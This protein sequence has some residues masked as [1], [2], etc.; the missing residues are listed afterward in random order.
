MF[1]SYNKW[2]DVKQR[3]HR[4]G[5]THG[6]SGDHVEDGL[7]KGGQYHWVGVIDAEQHGGRGPRRLLVH[8][9]R[10][11][12]TQSGHHLGQRP[13]DLQRHGAI[14]SCIIGPRK[15]S[16]YECYVQIKLHSG[17]VCDDQ[18]PRAQ[19]ASLKDELDMFFIKSDSLVASLSEST[20]EMFVFNSQFSGRSS[21]IVGIK[22]NT[23]KYQNNKQCMFSKSKR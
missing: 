8:Q 20:P 23:K 9:A 6:D 15:Q 5:C 11:V 14:R 22:E 17:Y 21:W 7:P 19:P 2:R 18:F 4:P 10:G 1:D 16:D 3:P 12:L 13:A